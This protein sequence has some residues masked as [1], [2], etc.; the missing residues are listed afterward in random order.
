MPPAVSSG[1]QLARPEVA[2]DVG[3]R[4]AL[5]IQPMARRPS[6][7]RTR[8]GAPRRERSAATR[9]TTSAAPSCMQHRLAAHDEHREQRAHRAGEG[10]RHRKRERDAQR[11]A[12]PARSPSDSPKI[13]SATKPRPK[14]SAFSVAYSDVALARRHRHRVGHHRHDD[15]DH[16]ER[17]A[18]IATTIAS[19]IATKPSWNAFS[20]SVS[21]SASEFLN[22]ASIVPETSAACAG[23]AGSRR[24]R[25][26]PGRR[27]AGSVALIVSFR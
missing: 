1:G 12:R 25:R 23:I 4:D 18:A 20:V 13:S 2:D 19:V 3:E 21:V 6:T 16:D 27:G 11:A 10:V 26:R 24:R 9:P 5:T 8:R 15:D 22:V 7:M 17:H 14:P